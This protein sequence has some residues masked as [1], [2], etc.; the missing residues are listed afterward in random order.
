LSTGAAAAASWNAAKIVRI[1][2]G[3]GGEEDVSR[4]DKSSPRSLDI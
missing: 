1:G 3:V 4:G 2:G